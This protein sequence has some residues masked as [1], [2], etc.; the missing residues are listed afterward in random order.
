V[1]RNQTEAAKLLIEFGV[2]INAQDESG[3][4]ALH[5]VCIISSLTQLSS[6]TKS[7]LNKN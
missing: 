5:W 4:T 2:D 7:L 6:Q 3:M 1:F